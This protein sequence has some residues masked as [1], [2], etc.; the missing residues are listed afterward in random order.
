MTTRKLHYL[1]M[2][3]LAM[4]L[5]PAVMSCSSTKH[6]PDG[7]MLLDDVK[8]VIDKKVPDIHPVELR[9]YL[10]QTEN[11]KVLG[12][13]KLQLAFYNLSG[14]DSSS[15]F[16]R[17]IQRVGTP[18]V[19]Y[20]STLTASSALQLHTALKNK[21]YMNNVVDYDVVADS[22]HK[23]AKVNYNITLGSPY[24]ISSIGYD[25]ANDTLRDII[26]EDTTGYP[27]KVGGLFDRNKLDAWRQLITEKLRNHGY[28]AFNKE[29]ITFT[30]DTAAGS[31]AIDVTLTATSACPTTRRTSHSM[32]AT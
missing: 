17:W 9:N 23:K 12:G 13:L 10:R 28:Y 30:A 15:W 18:P 14:K 2:A 22:A 11:H 29:Y 25:I 31:H 32:C 20:D 7:K 8:I 16:N 3:V 4:V 6:V 24:Y 27:V 21:G 26:L 19:I 1:L 5:L